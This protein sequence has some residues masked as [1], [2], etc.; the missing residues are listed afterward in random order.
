MNELLKKYRDYSF[1]WNLRG[2]KF[3]K[4]LKRINIE[5]LLIF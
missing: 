2:S 3:L 5:K 4:K 1:D